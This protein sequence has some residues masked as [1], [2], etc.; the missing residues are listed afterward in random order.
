VPNFAGQLDSNIQQLHSGSYRRPSDVTGQSALVVGFGTSGAEIAMEL[1]ANGRRVWISGRPTPHIPNVLPR[2]PWNIWWRNMHHV[3]TMDTP[4]GR[5]AIPKMRTRG[6]PLIRVTR[7]EVIASGVEH[8]RR[9]SG[10]VQGRPKLEDGRSLDVNA[11]VWCTGFR[12][13]YRFI[14]IPSVPVDKK[15][16]PLAPHGVVDRIPGLYFLGVPFQVGLTSMLVGGAGRDAELVVRHL[17]ER[18]RAESDVGF[19]VPAATLT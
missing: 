16:W 10:V 6:A 17:V 19:A 9:V 5:R 7:Q 18:S 4:I 13:D 1:A 2:L 3:L 11:I 14:D 12:P 8:V 15:G